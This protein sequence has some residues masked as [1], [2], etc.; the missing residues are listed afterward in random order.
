MSPKSPKQIGFC[1]FVVHFISGVQPCQLSSKTAFRWVSGRVR[2][3]D[4][5]NHNQA[6][7][8]LNY[9]HHLKITEQQR[10]GRRRTHGSTSLCTDARYRSRGAFLRTAPHGI[11][12]TPPTWV[13]PNLNTFSQTTAGFAPLNFVGVLGT[14]VTNYSEVLVAILSVTN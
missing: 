2:T 5:L 6:F 12:C 9:R 4:F 7:C 13:N 1:T 3:V 10:R 8:Q 14:L 11:G